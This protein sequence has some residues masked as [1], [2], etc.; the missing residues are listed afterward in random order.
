MSFNPL[1]PLIHNVQE[2]F[3]STIPSENNKKMRNRNAYSL[4]LVSCNPNNLEQK[5]FILNE[6]R[7]ITVKV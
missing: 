7:S 5:N 2:L 3:L 1:K 6:N 4:E